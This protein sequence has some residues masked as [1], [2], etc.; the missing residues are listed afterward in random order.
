MIMNDEYKMIMAY[1]KVLAILAKQIPKNVINIHKHR[2]P[3]D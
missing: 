3:D 2:I 1:L